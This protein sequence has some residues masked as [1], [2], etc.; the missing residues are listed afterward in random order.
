MAA[1]GQDNYGPVR[2]VSF[3][4]F[5]LTTMAEKVHNGPGNSFGIVLITLLCR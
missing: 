1:R 2:K 5:L 3:L 4:A